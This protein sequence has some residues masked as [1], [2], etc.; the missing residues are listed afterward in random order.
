M[1]LAVCRTLA[2]AFLLVT[3]AAAAP[4]PAAAAPDARIPIEHFFAQRVIQGAT[5]SPD[6]KR[7]AFLGP[8]KTRMSVMLYDVATEKLE[9]AVHDPKEEIDF[10]FW[11]GNDTLLFAGDVGGNE[12]MMYGSISLKTRKVQ[13]LAESR[14]ADFEVTT[15]GAVIDPL[16]RLPDEVAFI[17]TKANR[18]QNANFDNPDYGIYLLN[19]HNGS[20]KFLEPIDGS[21]AGWVTDTAGALRLQ[22]RYRGLNNELEYRAKPSDKW[23]V[24]Y[25][26]AE[27]EKAPWEPLCFAADNQTLYVSTVD[28]AEGTMSVRLFNVGNRILGEPLFT[29]KGAEISSYRFE[30]GTNKLLGVETNRDKPE[31]HWI[32]E[33]FAKL[34][35][36]LKNTLP[37]THNDIISSSQDNQV[38]LIVSR[39]DRTPATYYVLDLRVGKMA[40][41]SSA[42]PDIDPE[43]MRPMEPIAFTARDGTR[44]PGYLT[45]PATPASGPVPLILH[46]HGGPYGV[47]DDWGF[48]PEVQFLANR[49]YAILQVNYRGSGGLGRNHQEI[50]RGEWG[51]KMQDDL[52][53]AVKWAIDQKIADPARIAVYGA[54]YGGY[55]ALAALTFTPELFKCGV[56]YVGVSD[57]RYLATYDGEDKA[58]R[59]F[60]ETWVALDSAQLAARSPVNFVERIRVPSLHIYGLND[61][62]VKIEHWRRLEAELKKHNKPYQFIEAKDEGHG[63]GGEANRVDF[64]RKLED[65]F[66]KNL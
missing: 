1:P 14:K 59:R 56:N 58:R 40:M 38:H 15:E 9:I 50:G 43:K 46:P 45:R 60:F 36:K 49:G 44:I 7:V 16:Y 4:A 3:A 33:S 51:A 2:C 28:D 48:I 11:K 13:R 53:D 32:D 35:T 23:S 39:S 21:T 25:K 54:S 47:R 26:H 41:L 63:F 12:S 20:R 62:R 65:F 5:L 22:V 64:Y 17:G 19:V 6:G 42:L 55:A 66:A 52:T 61:P 30:D 18:K 24:L 31:L 8:V 34:A 27:K 57:L 29:S 37:D 10:V